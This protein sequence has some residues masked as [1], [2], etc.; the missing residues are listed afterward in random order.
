MRRSRRRVAAPTLAS[1]GRD[2]HAV[3]PVR[4]RSSAA[5]DRIGRPADPEQRFATAHAEIDL[6]LQAALRA[7]G[8]ELAADAGNETVARARA[9]IEGLIDR[10][11][12]PTCRVAVV[13]LA[14]SGK[15]TLVNA[16]LGAD[17]LPT[18]NVPETAQVVRV[19]HRGEAGSGRLL[20]ADRTVA[21][22]DGEIRAHLRGLNQARRAQ[23]QGAAPERSRCDGT[24]LTPPSPRFAGRGRTDNGGP[25]GSGDGTAGLDGSGWIAS[26]GELVLEAPLLAIADRPIGALPF[27]IL[28]TPGP[29]EAGAEELRAE[30]DRLL[31]EADVVIYLLDY[32]KLRTEEERGLFERLQQ[33]RPELL[34]RIGE[35]LFFAVN[36][37]DQ[38]NSRGLSQAETRDYVSAALREQLP[39]LRLAPERVL[40]LS[41]QQALLA[42]LVQAGRADAGALR[43]FARLCFGLRGQ[44]GAILA[45][46]QRHAG[47][48]LADSGL[49]AL[50]EV[51]LSHLYEGRG[52]IFLQ[53][54]GD[55]LDRHLASLANHLHATAGALRLEQGALGVQ[56]GELEDDR[57]AAEQAFSGLDELARG[58]ADRLEAWVR[59]RFEAFQQQVEGVVRSVLETVEE[60]P[61][62]SQPERVAARLGAADAAIAGRLRV[63]FTTFWLELERAAWQRQRE[64]FAEIE[65]ALAPLAA[66]IEAT[67][68]QRLAVSLQPV[69]L[70]L[71]APA[72]EALHDEVE[73]RIDG[74]LERQVRQETSREARRV[75]NPRAG[76]CGQRYQDIS[77]EVT[78][79]IALYGF[80]RD[81]VLAHW[82]D[83][84]GARTEASAAT[85]RAIIAEQVG[86]ALEQAR[87]QLAEHGAGYARTARQALATCRQGETRRRERLGAVEA[88]GA[89]VAELQE[90]LARCREFIA[91]GET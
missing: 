1:I 29:N 14:K 3:G 53:A 90:R 48:L 50:E 65:A 67:V 20:R 76:W 59:G 57:R 27:E 60:E 72:L 22:G 32:T 16:L 13:A 41:A 24:P 31:G 87:R 75:V 6:L 17:L 68:S 55:D 25:K 36:K 19:R 73:Q 79:Q 34:A 8:A 74:L 38:E 28:D 70:R 85:A 81:K 35:R 44:A 40:L 15:S 33:L 51:V 30:V 23:A 39:G 21:A 62:G 89:R 12:A 43:D 7:A 5:R 2:P 66:A 18:S 37:I 77:V 11:G 46:C 91:A 82:R 47:P 9:G 45:H 10:G 56:I 86:A 63:A 64:L 80:S 42:R 54:L 26:G 52:R 58:A 69:P 88:A 71:P 83:W 84:I 49:P 4:T 61:A 78:R